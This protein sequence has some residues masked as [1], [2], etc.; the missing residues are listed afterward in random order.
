MSIIGIYS[1]KNLINGKVYVGSSSDIRKRWSTHKRML[2]NNEHYNEHLQKSWNKYG[3]KNFDFKIIE[4]TDLDTLL[5]REQYWID[6]YGSNDYKKGFNMCE[7]AGSVLGLKWSETAR[8]RHSERIKGRKHTDE[9]K[10][11][12]SESHKGKKMNFKDE[13]L[14]YLSER[15]KGKI[16]DKNPFFGKKHTDETKYKIRT[17]KLGSTTSERQ[18]ESVRISNATRA[19]SDET[20]RKIS[21]SK[22]KENLSKET[23]DKLS[24]ANKG[25]NNP[26]SKLTE[27]DV[28][29]IKIMLKNKVTQQKIADKF[30]VSRSLIGNIKNNK[31]W[32][33][34]EVD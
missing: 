7:V 16:G 15:M 9:T 12:I 3:E 34:V 1:I 19:I 13:H 2:D 17:S 22:K 4:H 26:N 18:K 5:K 23:R 30:N 28:K 33:H 27:D 25:S 24:N 14:Q 21:E 11:K 29:E 32:Q 20:R 10:L 31:I 6:F 8:K